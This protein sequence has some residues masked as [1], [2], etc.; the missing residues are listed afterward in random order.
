MEVSNRTLISAVI[1]VAV[2]IV[3]AAYVFAEVVHTSI[4]Y[5][6]QTSIGT[7]SLLNR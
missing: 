6:T 5:Q 3:L 4:G 7:I 1:A 2:N